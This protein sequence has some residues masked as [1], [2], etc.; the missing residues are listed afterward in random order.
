MPDPPTLP[1]APAPLAAAPRPPAAV[2]ALVDAFP[3][4]RPFRLGGWLERNGFQPF[5]T[6]L[7]VFVLA[8]LVFNIV[9]ALVIGLGVVAEVAGSGET[10]SVEAM[11]A[12]L[13]GRPALVLTSNTAGQIVGFAL[14]ALLAAR[15][16]TRDVGPFLRLQRPALGGVGLAVLGW[17]VLYP[18]VLFAG[19]LNAQLPLP[20]WLRAL[21][22]SQTEMIEDL[23]TGGDLSTAFLLVAVA[24]TPAVAEELIFRGYLHRQAE[25]L[26]GSA[27]AI[28]TVGILFGLYHLRL[29]QA[30]PLSLLGVYLG[31]VVWA[32]GSVWTGTVVHLLNNGLAVVATAYAS[33]NPDVIDLEAVESASV[34]LPVVLLCAVAL[35]GVCRWIL[36][37]RRAVAPDD[38]AQPVAAVP[39]S[40]STPLPA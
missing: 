39:P 13:T 32:T 2:P 34:P 3:D 6:A 11:Q 18:I 26:R 30:L 5:W 1:E 29:S 37:R 28:V 36:A 14:F 16:S 19:E 12:M 33:A 24:L 4:S 17:V 8:F 15:L 9:G 25:R 38:D 31:F 27:F 22:E 23:L 40:L 7:L 35:A 21:E 10:P 20:E